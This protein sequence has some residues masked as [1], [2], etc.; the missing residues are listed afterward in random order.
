M[1]KEIYGNAITKTD[2]TTANAYKHAMWNSAMTYD[3]GSSTAKKLADAHEYGPTN[4]EVTNMDLAN[5]S[6]G[7]AIGEIYR[8]NENLAMQKSICPKPSRVYDSCNTNQTFTFL[9]K[10]FT[11]TVFP[12]SDAYEVMSQM[13]Q[14]AI[15]E[16][17]LTILIP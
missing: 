17:V 5:N 16:G 6:I 3:M 7:R 12:Q 11:A 2:N 9:G 15:D 8:Y 1:G 10:E 13:V 4:L 14:H